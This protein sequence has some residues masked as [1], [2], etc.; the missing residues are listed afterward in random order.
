MI[1]FINNILNIQQFTESPHPYLLPNFLDLFSWSM[2]FVI[3]KVTEIL[4]HIIKPNK[5]YSQKNNDMPF[6]LMDKKKLLEALLEKQKKDI[7]ENI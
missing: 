3:E 7:E 2:P 1:K 5:K 4:Y 6:E